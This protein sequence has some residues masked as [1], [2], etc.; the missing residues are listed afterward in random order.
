MTNEFT[1][2]LL[3]QPNYEM[4]IGIR[5]EV[6]TGNQRCDIMNEWQKGLGTVRTAPAF[7][8]L[9]PIAKAVMSSPILSN[10]GSVGPQQAEGPQEE[11][12][13]GTMGHKRT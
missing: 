9:V 7:I 13:E 1:K 2:Q 11:V 12:P 10:T 4:N 6:Q 8:E 3:R 5:L